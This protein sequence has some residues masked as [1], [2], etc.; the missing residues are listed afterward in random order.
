MKQTIS[1]RIFKDEFSELTILH[2]GDNRKKAY[3]VQQYYNG[4]NTVKSYSLKIKTLNR[5]LE[6]NNYK[7]ISTEE[8]PL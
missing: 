6:R 5:I 8:I 2:N 7:L 4:I 1:K 3:V